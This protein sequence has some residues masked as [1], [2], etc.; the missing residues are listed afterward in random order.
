[1]VSA[2]QIEAG[3]TSSTTYLLR[4]T[5]GEAGQPTA[6]TGMPVGKVLA[7]SGVP[8]DGSG[9]LTIPRTNG[10]VAYL[11]G[12]DFR[13]PSP[14]FEGGK[15]AVVSI[16][17]AGTRFLRPL[18][19][20][21]ADDVNAEDNI[22]TVSGEALTIGVHGGEVVGVQV[23]ASPTS[24]AAGDPV[25]FAAVASGGLPGETFSYEWTFGDGTTASGESIAH[26]F[27]GSGTYEVRA[28]ALGSEE[29]GGES[30][31]AAVVVGN[32]P[33]AAGPGAATT[34]QPTGKPTGAPGKGH[35]GRGGK[36][37]QPSGAGAGRRHRSPTAR[38][39]APADRSTASEA[40]PAPASPALEP[41]APASTPLP[42]A[43]PTVPLTAP[44]EPSG[45]DLAEPP[46]CCSAKS[47]PDG[48]PSQSPSQGELVEGRLVGEYL[49][50]AASEAAAAG[51]PA[52]QGSRAAAG[53]VGSAGAG[54]PVVALIVV[55]LLAG[56]ALFEWRRSRPVR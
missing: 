4:A 41:P 21:K 6:R 50:P 12:E 52:G 37:G 56:G 48:S 33:T 19:A 47:P 8:F 28:T 26:A 43:P 1:M 32:P 24:T 16:D 55:A 36:G 15:P 34:T 35:G 42:E 14:A 31:S 54:A 11:P 10:T 51:P 3:S 2:G 9:Y 27:S 46:G 40:S 13:E 30:A 39:A 49:P 38:G 22:A 5:P 44:E 23:T 17:G 18:I 45:G 20:S 29:S 53:A 7:E 25:R